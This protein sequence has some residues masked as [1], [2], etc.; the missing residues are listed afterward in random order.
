MATSVRTLPIKSAVKKTVIKRET[1][2]QR[3]ETNSREA[4]IKMLV[5][6]GLGN[7]AIWSALEE[8]YQEIIPTDDDRRNPKHPKYIKGI[9]PYDKDERGKMSRALN[10]TRALAIKDDERVMN[11]VHAVGGDKARAKTLDELDRLNRHRFSW[12]VEELNETYGKTLFVHLEDHTDSKYR[13]ETKKIKSRDDDG[14]TIFTDK[15]VKTWVSGSW[16]TGDPMIPDGNGGFVTTRNGDGTRRLDINLTDQI[17]EIG[18]PESFI[19][20]WGGAPGAGKSKLAV[21]TC[22]KIIATTQES[23]LYINGEAEEE[24]FSMWVGHDTDPDLFVV[25]NTKFL[26]I[27]AVCDEAER[28][29]PRLI[30]IDSVQ[31]IAEWN[32]G[33]RGQQAVMLILAALKSNPKAGRPH[34]ILISQL[35]KQNELKGARDLEHLADA[36]AN[37][38]QTDRDQVSQFQIPRKNRGGPT[39]AGFM[40]KHLTNDVE[41]FS[42]KQAL[43]VPY[44]LDVAPGSAIAEGI[45]D[46]PLSSEEETEE[47][48]EKK[49]E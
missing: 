20:I 36:V 1:T 28:R 48:G 39:P 16:R 22:K 34:I 37:V 42:D 44:Q 18:C 47:T 41:C 26:P 3:P 2:R 19:S 32:K 12:G 6:V 23:I 40:F 7:A 21:K 25:I 29:K 49:A 13:N 14:K 30:V 10:S 33:L 17:V 46:L 45:A 5:G 8:E 9:L 43:R 31:M 11:I 27:Q 4:K 35:N 24:D 38:V 15:K